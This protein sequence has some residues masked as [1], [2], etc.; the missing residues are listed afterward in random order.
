V[1]YLVAGKGTFSFTSDSLRMTAV[2]P[3]DLN[4][5]RCC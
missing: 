4:S 3:G 5:L 1:R 2:N